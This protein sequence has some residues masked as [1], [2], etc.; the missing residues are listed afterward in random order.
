MPNNLEN[1]IFVVYSRDQLD[2]K[3]MK[4][5]RTQTRIFPSFSLSLGIVKCW[6]LKQQTKTPLR[7]ILNRGIHKTQV[8]WNISSNNN[9][10]S[11]SFLFIFASFICGLFWFVTVTSVALMLTI[12]WQWQYR[13][14]DQW[15]HGQHNEGVSCVNIEMELLLSKHNS[16]P[17][18][19]SVENGD[20]EWVKMMVTSSYLSLVSIQA[21]LNLL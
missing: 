10:V 12:Q 6:G 9:I 3:T 5:L 8:W 11:S 17:P 4:V 2:I 14:N 19:L 18:I 13:D 16:K 1:P 7:W 20:T 15:R 21:V